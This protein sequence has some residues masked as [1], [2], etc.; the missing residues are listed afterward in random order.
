[1]RE[2]GAV[3][4]GEHFRRPVG[5]LAPESAHVAARIVERAVLGP[6]P[7][8]PVGVRVDHGDRAPVGRNLTQ[9][10]P[11]PEQDL[12]AIGRQKR[13]VRVLGVREAGEALF[14]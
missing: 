13:K 3:G 14:G 8:G 6:V 4:F 12:A 2:L 7:G 5:S 10:A 11:A 9:C 1:M